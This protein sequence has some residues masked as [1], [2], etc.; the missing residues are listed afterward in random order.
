MTAETTTPERSYGC[1]RGCGNP[2]D[3]VMISVATAHAEML[4]LPCFITTS[5]D[6][7]KA[8]TEPEDST[9]QAAMAE[10]PPEEQAPMSVPVARQ[11]GHH[12]PAESEDPDLLAAFDGVITEDE[13]PEA[14]R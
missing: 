12:A 14:F 11:R 9:V 7:V 4:C 8:V 10:F 13:L 1:S 6:V 3:F 5:L 2:Y